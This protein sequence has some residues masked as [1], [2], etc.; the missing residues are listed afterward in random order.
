LILFRFPTS[1]SKDTA[2]TCMISCATPQHPGTAR[3]DC[4]GPAWRSYDLNSGRSVRTA[5]H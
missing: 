2:M 1:S 3:P 4:H 5:E